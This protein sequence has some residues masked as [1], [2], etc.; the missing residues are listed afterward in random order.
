LDGTPVPD[1]DCRNLILYRI[2]LK[3]GWPLFVSEPQIVELENS[4]V[5]NP[6]RGDGRVEPDQGFAD[7]G[8]YGRCSAKMS[9]V[10]KS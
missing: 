1:E 9:A 10:T 3:A 7:H 6:V 8:E 2:L 5:T 4:T